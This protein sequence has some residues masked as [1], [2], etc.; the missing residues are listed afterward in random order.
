MG[1]KRDKN[2]KRMLDVMGAFEDV[3]REYR[4]RIVGVK[5]DLIEGMVRED[6][7]EEVPVETLEKVEDLLD[8]F[9]GGLSD[10]VASLRGDIMDELRGLSSLDGFYEDEE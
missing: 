5:D 1:A 6:E 2:W 3:V 4:E 9:E 10:E 8:D 7:G